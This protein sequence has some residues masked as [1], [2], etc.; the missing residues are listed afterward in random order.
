MITNGVKAWVTG[1]SLLSIVVLAGCAQLGGDSSKLEEKVFVEL[2]EEAEACMERWNSDPNFGQRQYAAQ[3]VSSRTL[4]GGQDFAY[5][6]FAPV[7]DVS[8]E[9]EVTVAA[10]DIDL[11]LRAVTGGPESTAT[12][13]IEGFEYLESNRAGISEV[14][15]EEVQWNAL[16]DA[17]G[18]AGPSTTRE[19]QAVSVTPG[20]CLTYWNGS[21]NSTSQSIVE[22]NGV[23]GGAPKASVAPD[24]QFPDRCVVSV[25]WPD[26]GTAVVFRQG[27][28]SQGYIAL[29][30]VDEQALPPEYAIW[31]ATAEENGTLS[32]AD[33]SLS[34]EIDEAEAILNRP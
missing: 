20:Y 2:S 29:E 31:N 18:G 16:I 28:A 6:S 7:P 11:G 30:E 8:G 32:P 4:A 1:M 15:P 26:S 17:E 23:L 19:A 27:T 10:P 22:T 9:C 5:A 25:S 21:V 33:D 13:E 14:V 24:R 3:I 34:S 12:G